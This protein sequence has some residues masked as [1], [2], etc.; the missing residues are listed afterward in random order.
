MAEPSTQPMP[1]RLLSLDAYR[2]FIMLAMASGGLG[3]VQL[4]NED[5]ESNML[6]EKIAYQLDHSAWRGCSFWDLIQ[7]AFI[8]MVGVA[9]VY[10]Y[11]RRRA[12]GQSWLRMFLHAM[13]RSVV[14]VLLGVFLASA[15]K[16]QTEWVFT[17]VLAQ[18]GLGYTF[19]F[20][21]LGRAPWVQVVAAVLILAADWTAFALHPLPGLDFYWVDVGVYPDWEHMRGFARHWEKNVNFAAH[22][23]RWL[24]NLFPRPVDEPFKYNPGGYTTLNFVPS[25]ATMILGVLAGE[26]LRSAKHSP[27]EKLSVV[28]IIGTLG[29]ILGSILDETICPVIKRIWTPSWVI[30]SGGWVCLM[31]GAFYGV[32]DVFRL[33]RWAFPLVVAGTNSIAMYLMAQLS[34]GWLRETLRTHAGQKPFS[35]PNGP[36]IESLGVLFIMWLVC[37]WMYRRKIFLKI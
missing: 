33:R 21:L 26:G 30:Y 28:L 8:F 14:L 17:N 29:I 36:I 24:L 1:G 11:D 7:P 2:G 5:Q 9:M 31:L 22:F 15:G 16:P 13:W 18:I 34:K 35:G 3:I 32:I 27:R 10:S 12:D 23:D 19:V 4:V 25:I 6:W 20:L 37:F